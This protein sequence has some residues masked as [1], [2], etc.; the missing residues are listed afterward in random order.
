MHRHEPSFGAKAEQC[1]QEC[2]RRA[3][4]REHR[5]AHGVEGELPATPL[6]HSKGEQDRDRTEMRDQDIQESRAADFGDAVL[7]RHEEIGRQRHRFPGHHEGVRI[8]GEQQKSHAGE[9]QVVLQAE[10]PGKRAEPS[11]EVAGRERRNAGRRYAE[12]N[13]EETR[14]GIDA[15]VHRKIRQAN[16]QHGL[17]GRRTKCGSRD[18]RESDAAKGSEREQRSPDEADAPRA[19]QPDEPYQAPEA[20]DR[21]TR[22]ER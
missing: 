10:E 17:F 1:E 21:E 5:A 16:A 20:K 9:E 6:Q 7:R 2:K 11:A 13:Q 8:V 3:L 18:D 15:N 12:Q 19:Q 4:R 14:E 22:A